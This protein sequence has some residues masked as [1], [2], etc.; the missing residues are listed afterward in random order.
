[1]VTRYLV[2]ERGL[3]PALIE[4]LVETGEIYADDRG[5]AVFVLLGD[6]VQPVGDEIRG[7]TSRPFR[8]MAPGSRKAGEG[9]R[10]TRSAPAERMFRTSFRRTGG[11]RRPRWEIPGAQFFNTVEPL[12]PH[13]GASAPSDSQ[14]PVPGQPAPTGLRKYQCPRY[15]QRGD[16]R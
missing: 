15:L 12:C 4:P 1:M 14:Y 11:S 16:C 5:N 2:R 6:K 7:T 8:G 9:R 3:A 10:A 13:L